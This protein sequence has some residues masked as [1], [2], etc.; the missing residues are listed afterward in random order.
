M[1]DSILISRSLSEKFAE[2]AY[3]RHHQRI[4][5]ANKIKIGVE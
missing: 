5:A 4:A 2:S 3:A 1:T